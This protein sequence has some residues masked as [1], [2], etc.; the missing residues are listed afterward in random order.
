M[1][2]GPFATASQRRA[3]AGDPDTATQ[4]SA[5]GRE[6]LQL[7]ERNVAWSRRPALHA[8]PVAAGTC[9]AAV[10]VVAS[11]ATLAEQRC[12]GAAM[13]AACVLAAGASPGACA[14]RPT[15]ARSGHASASG[16]AG[17]AG[18][19]VLRA[20]GCQPASDVAA[21]LANGSGASDVE[22][23]INR[24]TFGRA[25]AHGG[26]GVA[27]RRPPEHPP[28]Q[29]RGRGTMEPARAARGRCCRSPRG[30]V[31]VVREELVP[32]CGVQRG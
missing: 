9:A 4:L 26:G 19:G 13:S 24:D 1:S 3:T 29:A 31:A 30:A 25:G 11:A 5:P 6:R 32:A 18:A 17:W 2:A 12:R 22:A 21:V 16:P 10:D 23:G 8:A 28:S 20:S 14:G 15:L 27:L 7:W